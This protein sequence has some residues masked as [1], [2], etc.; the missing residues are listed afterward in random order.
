MTGLHSHSE[1]GL[2]AETQAGVKTYRK[3]VNTFFS[4]LFFFFFL[5]FCTDVVSP[6]MQEPEVLFSCEFE[7]FMEQPYWFAVY[8]WRAEKGW[9]VMHSILL[10]LTPTLLMAPAGSPSRGGDVT[11]YVCDINQP[12]LPTP[13]YSVLVSISD[14]MALSTAFHSINS[15]DNFPFSHSLL[16][17]LSLPFWSLQL[18]VS[19]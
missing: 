13:F 10:S 17:V 12:S 9:L 7:L 4:L 15:P 5:R 11:V 1:R 19:L 16:P 8:Q 3:Y 18:Y 6:L 2:E 14:F